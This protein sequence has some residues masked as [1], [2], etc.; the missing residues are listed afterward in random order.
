LSGLGIGIGFVQ[1]KTIKSWFMVIR[2]WSL[3]AKVMD[4]KIAPN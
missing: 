3:N 4:E 1:K 2:I